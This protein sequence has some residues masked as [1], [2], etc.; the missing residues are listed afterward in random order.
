MAEPRSVGDAEGLV[1]AGSR[2]LDD[3]VVAVVELGAQ[4]PRHDRVHHVERRD[5]GEL[6]DLL[7]GERR[8]GARRT[9]R[10]RPD[11]GRARARRCTRAPPVRS[12]RSSRRPTSGGSPRSSPRRRPRCAATCSAGRTRTGS[13]RPSRR[14]VCASSRS[15]GSRRRVGVPVEREAGDAVL[16]DLGH[17]REHRPPVAGRAGDGARLGDRIAIAEEHRVERPATDG[18]ASLRGTWRSRGTGRTLS[19]PNALS[20]SVGRD[21]PLPVR[22]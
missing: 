2:D 19:R 9:R 7:V 18:A 14:G 3:R 20:S 8:R 10:R 1:V 22:L 11:R 6:E 17:Q 16:E 21:G 13:R 12:A 15:C 4:R 5:V